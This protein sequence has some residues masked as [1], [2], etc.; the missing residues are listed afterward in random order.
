MSVHGRKSL[1]TFKPTDEIV[2][3]EEG[4]R[5]KRG[6]AGAGIGDSQH[7]QA[8]CCVAVGMGALDLAACEPV[9]LILRAQ[10]QD[11][12]DEFLVGIWR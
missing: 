4:Q 10:R 11:S 5:L 12:E 9:G 8:T 1:G 3:G 6:E 2:E 7:D